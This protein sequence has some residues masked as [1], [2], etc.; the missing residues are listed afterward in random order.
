M[1]KIW[2]QALPEAA[3]INCLDLMDEA[4]FVKEPEEIRGSIGTARSHDKD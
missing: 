1:E 2:K 4:T 3:F